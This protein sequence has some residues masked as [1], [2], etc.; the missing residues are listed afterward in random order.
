MEQRPNVNVLTPEEMLQRRY[1]VLG[2][3]LD[4]INM[5]L[6]LMYNGDID[7]GLTKKYLESYLGDLKN[8]MADE[9]VVNGN[10]D[11]TI[12]QSAIVLAE[13]ELAKDIWNQKCFPTSEPDDVVGFE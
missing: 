13:S 10:M 11:T 1:N 9:R 8:F 4:D 2:T 5:Y 3:S 6:Q 7:T 12:M